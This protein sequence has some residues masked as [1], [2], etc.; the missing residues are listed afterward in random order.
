MPDSSPYVIVGRTRKVHGLRGELV[1]E[2]HT[3]DPDAVFA[4][5][6]ALHVGSVRGVVQPQ[7]LEITSVRPF[8]EGVIVKFAGIDDRNTAELWKDRFL[9]LEADELAPL[10]EN[11][12]YIHELK[13]MRVQLETGDPV[14]TVL[15]TYEL[16]QGL[17]LDV[18]R[19]DSKSI[20]IPYDRIVTSVDRAARVIRLDP[21][22]GLID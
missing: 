16:P 10:A 2:M 13:G 3:D 1:V 20:I 7:P 8:K 6:R 21:P 22:E 4:R 17:A 12:V 9:F 14:G 18:S 19:P 15:D 5:G 11:Q